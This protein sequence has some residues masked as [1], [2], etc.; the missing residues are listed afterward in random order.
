MTPYLTIIHTASCVTNCV[1]PVEIIVTS[2]DMRS[3]MTP[4]EILVLVTSIAD[5]NL[6][7]VR[8]KKRLAPHHVTIL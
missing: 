8:S 3:I 1:T 4:M 2:T 7:I 5:L 6:K